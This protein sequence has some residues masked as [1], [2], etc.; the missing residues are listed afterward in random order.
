MQEGRKKK[1]EI[2]EKRIKYKRKSSNPKVYFKEECLMDFQLY[3]R[4]STRA[5]SS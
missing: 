4:P 1:K 2:P 5:T 3:D